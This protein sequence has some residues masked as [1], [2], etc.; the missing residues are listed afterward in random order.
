[1]GHDEIT[2]IDSFGLE[3]KLQAQPRNASMPCLLIEEWCHRRDQ[4]NPRSNL[5]HAHD[6]LLTLMERKR[7]QSIPDDVHVSVSQ[8]YRVMLLKAGTIAVP[9]RLGDDLVLHTA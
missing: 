9:N 8:V 6:R 4:M 5:H 3:C 7:I 2:L 1:M